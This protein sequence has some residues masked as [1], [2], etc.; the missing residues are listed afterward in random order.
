MVGLKAPVA[1]VASGGDKVGIHALAADGNP[2]HRRV[3][4]GRRGAYESA[5]RAAGL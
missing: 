3:R 2:S 5:D 1:A 4:R